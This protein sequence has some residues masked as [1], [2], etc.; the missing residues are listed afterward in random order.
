LAQAFLAQQSCFTLLE[1]VPS[2]PTAMPSTFSYGGFGPHELPVH[3]ADDVASR[4]Q[5]ML[6][7]RQRQLALKRQR[8]MSKSG[9]GVTAQL[10]MPLDSTPPH[11][12]IGWGKML[13]GF[14]GPALAGEKLPLTDPFRI[15]VP[16]AG[17][18]SGR[19]LTTQ[20][21]SSEVGGQDVSKVAKAG[22]S[23]FNSGDQEHHSNTSPTSPRTTLQKLMGDDCWESL[24][25]SKSS[26][27]SRSR[28]FWRPWG[29][30]RTNVMTGT[31]VEERRVTVIPADA[32][33]SQESDGSHSVDRASTPY[34]ADE[35]PLEESLGSDVSSIPGF[36]ESC[37]N[38][39]DSSLD[40]AQPNSGP[41]NEFI[42][43]DQDD[44]A[45]S[46]IEQTIC[47]WKGSQD[48]NSSPR[49]KKSRLNRFIPNVQ[50]PKFWRAAK[51]GSS[52]THTPV[53][54]VVAPLDLD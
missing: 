45:D 34:Q 8:D 41:E 38:G 19:T 42:E 2:H 53:Q 54:P 22:D 6:Q 40:H 37:D 32:K 49:E 43:K 13:Q 39:Q 16:P 28:S 27:K 17:E 11:K 30:K 36:N 50:A 35:S 25:D 23:T 1:V 3:S 10:D 12:A 14:D 21:P 48:Q 24:S 4:Q 29:P 33:D 18:E 5:K 47:D 15:V 26:E 46:G 9:A 51:A 7:Q 31:I 44:S 20:C 52:V